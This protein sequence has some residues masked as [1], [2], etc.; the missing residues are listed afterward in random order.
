[1]QDK[2]AAPVC[3]DIELEK[4]LN[5]NPPVKQR[6]ESREVKQVT[7]EQIQDKLERAGERKAQTIAAQLD[8]VKQTT[9]KVEQ[10]QERKS[11]M[12][13]ALGQQKVEGLGKKLQNAEEK[14]TVQLTNIQ[15]KAKNHNNKVQLVRERK[16]SQER[17]QEEKSKTEL[18]QKLTTAEERLVKK[19]NDVQVKCKTHNEK[20]QQ[21]VQTK[22]EES[23]DERDAKK[24]KIEDKMT[25]TSS[26]KN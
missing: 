5:A 20:V 2:N 9:V 11:S 24:A 25:R 3:I 10:T 14:R 17:A 1:M 26:F 6:L 18:N 23:K 13:R 22:A 4:E 8:T 16:T 7:M 15:E 12:E 21:N 19:L